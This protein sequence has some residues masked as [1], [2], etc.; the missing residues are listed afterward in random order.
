MQRQGSR[1]D[2]E[3]KAQALAQAAVSTAAQAARDLQLPERTVRRWVE[4]YAAENGGEQWAADNPGVIARATELLHDAMDQI[5]ERGE[6]YKHVMALNALRGTSIDKEQR[7]GGGKR[8][9][10]FVVV[11]TSDGTEIM[12]G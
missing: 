9:G 6:A 2:R 4:R 3:T 8:Q 5:E 11:R 7:A 1:Y 12:A 10:S